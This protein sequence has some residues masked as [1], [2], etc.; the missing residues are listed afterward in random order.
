[1]RMQRESWDIAI[2][3]GILDIVFDK[4]LC[5]AL[6]GIACS[7]SVVQILVQDDVQ[8]VSKFIGLHEGK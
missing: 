5:R 3:K 7:I 6:H 1:M 4:Q 8:D 2:V